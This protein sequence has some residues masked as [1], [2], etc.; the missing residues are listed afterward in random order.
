[1]KVLGVIPARYGSTRFPGK[2]LVSLQGRPLIHWVVEAA[3]K[4]KKLSQ[5]IVA[6]DDERIRRAVDEMKWPEVSVVMTDSDLPS[7]TDRV[8]AATRGHGADVVV[9]IQGDEPLMDPGHIDLLVSAFTTS[10][11]MPE[12]ATLAHALAEED[13]LSMNAVKVVVDENNHAL[14][15]S[16]FAIPYS[17]MK[18]VDAPDLGLKHIGMYAYSA[19]FLEKFC[20][21]AP[22]A[23]E[24]AESL[25]QLRALSM[26]A[27][28][29]VFKVE[30]GSPGVDS[31]EDLEKVSRIMASRAGENL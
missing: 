19:S 2:P 13:I 23:L 31:P 24:L 21:K 22:S 17:R 6:T 16:R 14:Y 29:K 26:G 12:M 11:A 27:K 7:G 1:L 28:I 3:R 20:Q 5:V 9:N 4:S 18:R 15:F 30:R 8:Y 10:A 25:E